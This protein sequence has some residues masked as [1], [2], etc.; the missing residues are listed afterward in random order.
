[1]VIVDDYTIYTWVAFLREKSDTFDEFR[2]NCKRIINEKGLS[3]KKNRSDYGRKFENHKF[4]C[5][6]EELAIKHEFCDGVCSS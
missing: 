4:M 3:I 6:C 1:M 2:K 5:W